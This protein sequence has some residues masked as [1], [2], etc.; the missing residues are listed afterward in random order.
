MRFPSSTESANVAPAR[1]PHCKVLHGGGWHTR[2]GVGLS[3]PLRRLLQRRARLH[4]RS[5]SQQA[6]ADFEALAGG[7]PRQQRPAMH[8]PQAPEELIRSD[9][10][11]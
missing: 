1:S 3:R 8:W 7:D 10:N 6:L 11:R 9:R 5:L 2:C 4:K